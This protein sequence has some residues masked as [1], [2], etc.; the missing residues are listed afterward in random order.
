[1]AQVLKTTVRT[2][3]E[4]AA[5]SCFADQGYDGTT[6]AHI[7]ARAQTAPA[8]V[9][10]YFASKDAL[11]TAV[12]PA[13][14]ADRHNR[15]LDTRIATLAQPQS[16]S[17]AQELLDFWL[18]QRLAIVVLLDRADGTPYCDYPA[19][20]V[21]RL[22]DHAGRSLKHPLSAAHRQILELVFDNTR[23]ALAQI[24]LHTQD[25]DETRELIA[26]FWSYQIPGLNGLLG[27]LRS[28]DAG[29]LQ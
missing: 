26:A 10:R 4:A 11:F 17:A 15:L 12:I 5:L 21:Q 20:F 3:I 18:D 19:A 6:M 1:M 29:R 8:N 7:A 27:H 24:L 13:D 9:Y 16:T 28:D 2:R 25:R 22:V 23:R 14:L